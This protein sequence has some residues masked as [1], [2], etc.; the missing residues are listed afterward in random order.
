[1]FI[2]KCVSISMI[3]EFQTEWIKKLKKKNI[4]AIHQILFSK[5]NSFSFH[6]FSLIA[7]SS[8]K[9]SCISDLTF[10]LTTLNSTAGLAALFNSLIGSFIRFVL[11]IGPKMALWWSCSLLNLLF[12][13]ADCWVDRDDLND[14]GL[15]P[16]PSLSSLS[17]W[18]L[19][20]CS[21][22][23]KSSTASLNS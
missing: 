10:E 13:F 7:V 6:L 18:F 17:I 4:K 14:F 8:N 2:I 15:K 12:V 23:Y 5:S 11:V 9:F 1:M 19:L 22:L 21:F 3:I 16:P 20:V